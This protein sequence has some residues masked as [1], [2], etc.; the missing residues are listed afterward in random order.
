MDNEFAKFRDQPPS[1]FSIEKYPV[2]SVWSTG[3]VIETYR[4]VDGVIRPEKVK[5]ANKEFV[6][7]AASLCL[8]DAAS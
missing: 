5:T 6:R 8:L 7:P 2:R 4:G 3:C 1:N